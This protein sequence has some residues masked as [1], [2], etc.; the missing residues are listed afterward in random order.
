MRPSSSRG[1]PSGSG[2]GR[3]PHSAGR[4]GRRAASGRQ[5]NSAARLPQERR[6]QKQAGDSQAIFRLSAVAALVLLSL[7][8]LIGP[9]SRLLD[10]QKEMKDLSTQIADG[11]QEVA[12]L[13][14][15]ISRWNDPK[16]VQQEAANRL[17]FVVPGKKL[18]VI[19]DKQ[20]NPHSVTA[21]SQPAVASARPW[22]GQLWQ[23][24]S[25]PPE[26]FE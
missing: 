8:L 2:P 6:E 15:D 24:V 20:G 1:R 10:Q 13:R 16:F 7:M 17:G 22:Y 25:V 14:A 9:V 5:R 18:T 19:L 26:N 4:D 3:R 21:G 11:E 12:N 23:S